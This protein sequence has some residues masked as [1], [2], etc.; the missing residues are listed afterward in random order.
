MGRLT[1]LNKKLKGWHE[2]I[3]LAINLITL[4]INIIVMLTVVAGFIWG[5]YLARAQRAQNKKSDDQWTTYRNEVKQLAENTEAE[6]KKYAEINGKLLL[7]EAV[8]RIIATHGNGNRAVSDAYR[9]AIDAACI[10]RYIYELNDTPNEYG[11]RFFL[12]Q[13][14]RRPGPL[15]RKGS[16][17][18][19]TNE[20]KNRISLG[21]SSYVEEM[22]R[23][24]PN[25]ELVDRAVQEDLVWF[26]LQQPDS[27][28]GSVTKSLS[29][30]FTEPSVSGGSRIEYMEPYSKVGAIVGY[31]GD[32]LFEYAGGY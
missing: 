26:L 29:L 7:A 18:L 28:L 1:G 12:T 30:E 11:F 3:G 24:K 20:E 17:F 5:V 31:V 21:V 22:K 13:E 14:H 8:R 10:A 19:L 27:D 9:A 32:K 2:S 4:V 15:Y 23:T 16:S 25:M 6:A